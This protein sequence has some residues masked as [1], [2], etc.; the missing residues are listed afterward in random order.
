MPNGESH[1]KRRADS[2]SAVFGDA[3]GWTGPV[4]MFDDYDLPM[5]VGQVSFQ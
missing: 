1:D 2:A 5:Y 3:N 4:E